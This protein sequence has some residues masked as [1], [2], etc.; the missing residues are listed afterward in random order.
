ML[1]EFYETG[2]D[3]KTIHI[4]STNNLFAISIAESCMITP[5]F[6][7]LFYHFYKENATTKNLQL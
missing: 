6:Y 2:D 7:L 4:L 1:I 5:A 3:V